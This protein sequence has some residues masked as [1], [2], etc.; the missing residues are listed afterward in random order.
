MSGH[1]RIDCP[2]RQPERDAESDLAAL[3]ARIE[4]VRTM[5]RHGQSS[6]VHRCREGHWEN[7]RGG[8]RQWVEDDCPVLIA[9]ADPVAMEAGS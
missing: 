8:I 4:A 7:K 9:L 6:V 2:C 5:H 1:C 3:R